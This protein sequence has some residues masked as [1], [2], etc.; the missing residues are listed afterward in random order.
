MSDEQTGLG[1]RPC[2]YHLLCRRSLHH[3]P[4]S[5]GP[6]WATY[7]LLGGESLKSA[8]LLERLD[9]LTGKLQSML[10]RVSGHEPSKMEP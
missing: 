6:R 3:V 4:A 7:S 5:S 9:R 1:S 10:D 2:G 8:E